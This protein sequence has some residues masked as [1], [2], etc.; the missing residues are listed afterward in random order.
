MPS[1]TPSWSN[2]VLDHLAVEEVESP[3][4]S[5]NYDLSAPFLRGGDEFADIAGDPGRAHDDVQDALRLSYETL[6][7]D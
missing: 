1:D 7:V 5:D 4:G 3:R 6:P 2:L